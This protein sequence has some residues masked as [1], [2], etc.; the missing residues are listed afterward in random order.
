MWVMCSDFLA[1]NTRRA[2]ALKTDWAVVTVV[3]KYPRELSC[4]NPP[5]SPQVHALVSTRWC[6]SA[7]DAHCVFDGVL[8]NIDCSDVSTHGDICV[9]VD[10]QVSNCSYRLHRC[11]TNTNRTSRDL[12]LT[13]SGW[14]PDHLSL[15]RV[16]LQ[17]VGHHP[18]ENFV[19]A[20]R[21]TLLQCVNIRLLLTYQISSLL[22]Y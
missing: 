5:L 4:S 12:M 21:Q 19:N 11:V 1:E 9:N 17:P 15:G 16:E 18:G 13:S 6:V 14:T 3:R 22:L 10:P 20:D 2:A 7:N 8:Q